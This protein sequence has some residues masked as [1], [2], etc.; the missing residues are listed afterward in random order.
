MIKRLTPL[1][2][3]M[4]K[5]ENEIAL[6][7]SYSGL[8]VSCTAGYDVKVI[9]S[10]WLF[11]SIKMMYYVSQISETLYSPLNKKLEKIL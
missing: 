3:L 10:S 5:D 1:H 2:E 6:L 9:L 11:L 4:G 8:C 7:M